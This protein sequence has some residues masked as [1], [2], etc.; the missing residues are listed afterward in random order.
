MAHID[1]DTLIHDMAE[2]MHA[3][4]PRDPAMKAKR[5]AVIERYRELFACPVRKIAISCRKWRDRTYGNTYYTAY[6]SYLMHGQEHWE[7]FKH[8]GY[9]YGSTF[10]HESKRMLKELGIFAGFADKYDNAALSTMCHALNI[11]Y[12]MS[13]DHVTRKR[14]LHQL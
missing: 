10:E 5:D 11:E 9:G 14:D 8:G 2:L 6:V 1:T 12:E 4:R 3:S 13:E 7:G